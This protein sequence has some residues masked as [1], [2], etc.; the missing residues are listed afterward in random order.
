[1]MA[2][3]IEDLKRRNRALESRIEALERG[4]GAANMR[5][6]WLAEELT[7]QKELVSTHQ[8]EIARLRARA[9]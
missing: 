6:Q 2:S 1:M 4:L 3:D 5:V 8:V 9:E 7:T